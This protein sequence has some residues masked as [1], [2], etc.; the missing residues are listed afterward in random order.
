[1]DKTQIKDLLIQIK[2]FYPR[3]ELVERDGGSYM[4]STKVVDSW[5]DRLGFMDY[6]RALQILDSYMTGEQGGRVPT[7]SLWASGGK[8]HQAAVRCTATFDRR[9][10]CLSWRPDAKGDAYEIPLTWDGQRGAWTDSDGRLWAVPGE[11]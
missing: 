4:V 9:N 1:M 6:D 10:G 8:V 2:V 11:E 7:F 5:F 3:F